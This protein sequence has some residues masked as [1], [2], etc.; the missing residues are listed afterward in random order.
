MLTKELNMNYSLETLKAPI[1]KERIR[2][3]GPDGFSFIPHRFL[4][5]GYLS[6]LTN[7]EIALYV[8]LVLAANKH[9]VSFYTYDAICSFLDLLVDDYIAAR[10]NLIK[11]DLIAFDGRRFQVLELPPPPNL[12]KGKPL[13]S[14]K[15]FENHDP[16][17][18]HRRILESIP[19]DHDNFDE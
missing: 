4:K 7:N 12:L 6:T 8:F 10:N 5:E 14:E 2:K 18:I 3:I 17:T 19:F 9:G 13:E 16:A 15:D 11:K 1:I